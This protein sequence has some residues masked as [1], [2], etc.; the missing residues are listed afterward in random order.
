MLTNLNIHNHISLNPASPASST[1]HQIKHLYLRFNAVSRLVLPLLCLAAAGTRASAQVNLLPQGDF[2]NP[3]VNTS[4][5]EGFN[6]PQNDEFRV[7]TENGHSWLRIENH[8]AGRQL[9]YV[10][11]FVKVTPKIDSLT[12]SARLKATNLKVGT[13][14]WHVPALAL[15]FEGG[16]FGYPP[17]VPRLTADSDWV[18][19]TVELKV[20]PG[21]TRLNLQ[22]AMF[23]CTGVFEI[24]DITV[25]PHL[26]KQT[27]LGD[28]A[29]P[30][31]ILNWDQIKVETVNARRARASL[32]GAWHFIPAAEGA[33]EPP[34][35]GWAYIK[36]PGSWQNSSDFVAVGSGPQWDLFDGA[37][38]AHAWYVRQV[39]MPADWQGRAISLRFDRL[40]TDAIIYVN[41]KE[42]GQ[43]PW[44]W[45]SVDITSAVTPGQT[46][47]VRV[48]VAAIPDAE[49]VG[50]FW[51][52]AFMNVSYTAAELKSRGLTGNVYLEGRISDAHVTD[53][54]VHT[55]TRKQNISLDVE[56]TGVKQ[57]GQVHFVADMLDEKGN[58]EKS[59]TTDA[60]VE[61]KDVQTVAVSWPWENPR[62]WDVGQPNRYTLRLTV[63]GAG[64]DDQ[65]NQPFGFR[66]FWVDGRQFYLNGTVIHL[67]QQCFYWGEAPQV[68]DTFSEF[69]TWNPDTRGD[70]SDVSSDLDHADRIGYLGAVY[71]L[72]ANKFLRAPNG[73]LT[74]QQNAQRAMERAAV[75]MRHYGNHPSA[76]MWVAG[77]NFFNN[78]VDSDP[79]HIGRHGWI[80]DEGTL[81]FMNAGQEMFDGLKKLD[82]TRVYYSHEGADSG[83]AYVMNCYLNMIPLQERGD[84]LS[85]WA[86]NGDMPVA[87]N[88]F[89]TPV[90]CALRRGHHGFESN[91]TSEPL[92]TE[93]AAI[94]FGSGA[95]TVEEP[96]YRKYLHDLFRE[97]MLYNSSENQ[98]DVY[99][100]DH[101]IQLLFRTETWRDWRTAGLSGGLRTW[102]WM[103]DGLKELNGPTLAWIAGPAGDY[104]AKDH[105]F[106]PGQ[107]FQKQLVLI[108]DMRQPEDYTARWTATVGGQTV[109]QGQEHGTLAV[110]EIKF[111]PF[112]VTAPAEDT[113]SKADGQI[114]MTATIGQAQHQDTFAFRVLGEDKPARGRLASVDPDGLTGKMLAGLGYGTRVWNGSSA[115]LVIVGRNALK[116]NPA[117]LAQLEPYVQK[118]GRVLVFAQ[119]PDWLAQAIG[120]RI[121][122]KIA[123]RVFPVDPQVTTGMDADDL[124][125]WTGNSTLIEAYPVYEGDYLRGNEGG[126]P[127]AGWHW[128]NQGGVSSAAIEKPH[129][130][131]WRPLLECE[132][133]LAYSPLMELDYGQG[134]V[135]I[136]TLDLE[137][138]V[139]SDP[140]AKRMAE[141]VVDCALHSPLSP[142]ASKVV[143]LGGAT[144]AAWL[145]KAG[146]SY[147]KSD[148]LDT[149]AGLVLIGPDATVDAAALNGYLQQGGKAFFL[150]RQQADGALGTT[151]KPAADQFAGSLSPPDWPE[152]RG[153][154]ASDLRWRSYAEKA[155]YLLSSGADIGADGLLGRKV[156]GKGVAIFCQVDPDILNADVKTYMRYTRW[157]ATRTVSQLLANLG[158]S[159][160]VDS[161]FFHPLD[162]VVRPDRKWVAPDGDM[163]G[164][165][166]EPRVPGGLTR[167]ASAQIGYYYP[168]YRTDFPM[169]DNPYRYYRF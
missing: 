101:K 91:I 70:S 29:V 169:G 154:S 82:P 103:Q 131:G 21:A 58:V 149:S 25:T 62:L 111:L 72:D 51:Q 18:T 57:A 159:F 114:T 63:S 41:G 95:Y 11:A 124:R 24:A 160:T 79:S 138:H 132:F 128:G 143:Y 14:G 120:W 73:S 86:K 50:H 19:Q 43:V 121:C 77:A 90:D 118:G 46:A 127:Y 110:S 66:E 15:L 123:R 139:G 45:G 20:P 26:A 69:G 92:L 35:I 9:D 146:V 136:C 34:K 158:A 48:L 113:G 153:L 31:G 67:R 117:T 28:A 150:P 102:S 33:S 37:R 44:P 3:G 61:V 83:D 105:H 80:H 112:D 163:A 38:V 13:E 53:V 85:A 156:V 54:A 164:P 4:W 23:R 148:T 122:P 75:W 97:G 130:S 88:E 162:I 40:C 1:G 76:I 42:C 129:L 104:T 108:N 151:L 60:S 167:P 140:A 71:I 12:I 126:Q 96:K 115:P 36:V 135:I 68:G 27:E 16:S 119:D 39:P 157:R 47:D 100:N 168:D 22:P 52:N 144:G 137:D 142:R 116:N 56:L 2:K 8:D 55:S 74:W 30:A 78:A 125:D 87:M 6:I 94:Y 10:H 89:G 98:L 59:F 106:S 147:R 145:D 5:A 109:G 7:V 152:A 165:Q 32:N 134:R 99:T 155:P 64:L 161:R 133:D 93:Y 49:M 81:R 141:H 166:A 65:Y 107:K 17:A 84:W